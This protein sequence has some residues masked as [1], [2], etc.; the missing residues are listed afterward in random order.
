M[1]HN[2]QRSHHRLNNKLR[3]LNLVKM[4]F[5]RNA[6]DEAI[7]APARKFST[8]RSNQRADN[9]APVAA[10]APRGVGADDPI[11]RVSRATTTTT[12]TMEEKSAFLYFIP[13]LGTCHCFC[14]GAFYFWR[15]FVLSTQEI[16]RDFSF[17]I[18]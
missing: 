10:A 6:T 9:G 16:I 1:F 4:R 7:K 18:K 15:G 2:K 17:E 12:T 13:L 11:D 5:A 14:F 8:R 3:P